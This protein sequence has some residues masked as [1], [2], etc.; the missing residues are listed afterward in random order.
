MNYLNRKNAQDTYMVMLSGAR[1]EVPALMHPYINTIRLV[2]TRYNYDP[3]SQEYFPTINVVPY[4]RS[5]I[6]FLVTLASIKRDYKLITMYEKKYQNNPLYDNREIRELI[7]S[8]VPDF[9]F[10]NPVF[11][12]LILASKVMCNDFHSF[13]YVNEIV[14]YITNKYGNEMSNNILLDMIYK[15]L[16]TKED[17][18]ELRNINPLLANFYIM[19]FD[20]IKR[21]NLS[22]VQK[23]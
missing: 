19:N 15:G 16:I 18:E 8:R 5:F 17:L 13:S 3:N 11:K 9:D 20:F 22:L 23:R 10:N 21:Y 7:D 2:G 14:R 12:K 1:K 6:E 4:G